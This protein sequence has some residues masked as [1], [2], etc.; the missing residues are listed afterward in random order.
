MGTSSIPSQGTKVLH[1]V[2]CGQN[3]KREMTISELGY[4]ALDEQTCS[5]LASW[6]KV[7]TQDSF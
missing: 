3:N 1:A 2:Q 5:H 4:S 7:G 6:I